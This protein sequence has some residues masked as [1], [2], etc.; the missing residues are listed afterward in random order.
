M[1]GDQHQP[2]PAIALDQIEGRKD[3]QSGHHGNLFLA[4]GEGVRARHLIS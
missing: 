3:G 2:F 4:I 1:I